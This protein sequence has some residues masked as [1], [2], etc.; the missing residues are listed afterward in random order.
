MP[1]THT[2]WV[3]VGLHIFL[4]LVLDW[5]EWFA[6]LVGRFKPELR[7]TTPH[8]SKRKTDSSQELSGASEEERHL[9]FQESNHGSSVR[10][11]CSLVIIRN[12]VFRMPTLYAPLRGRDIYPRRFEG[13]CRLQH[14]RMR[15]PGRTRTPQPFLGLINAQGW[16]RYVP[17]KHRESITLLLSV[18][19]PRIRNLNINA[20]ETWNFAYFYFM[21]VTPLPSK[22][23]HNFA[24]LTYIP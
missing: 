17:S 2:G 23:N 8:P 22:M 7:H 9:F 15:N 24:T 4:I 10:A 14:H 18:T 19:S 16:R 1:L 12:T 3:E 11:A 21:L 13:T 6:S 20:A 5:G